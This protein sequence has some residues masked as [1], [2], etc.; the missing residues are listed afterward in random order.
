MNLCRAGLFI[1]NK[2][3]KVWGFCWLNR[4][5]AIYMWRMW[6]LSYTFKE[7]EI[8]FF[9]A[10]Q[11]LNYS[12]ICQKLAYISAGAD[13]LSLMCLCLR[14]LTLSLAPINTRG[15]FF[16]CA[17]LGR[18]KLPP[19]C[20]SVP[21]FIKTK[22]WPFNRQGLQVEDMINVKSEKWPF[23]CQGLQVY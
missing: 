16:K 18:G 17:C 14:I 5:W 10:A 6:I 11:A 9:F 3:V 22:M 7:I 23:T 12:E 20:F 15:L 13:G 8:E 21:L 1:D 19:P 2:N 4:R